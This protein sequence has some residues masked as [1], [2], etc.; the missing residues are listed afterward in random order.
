[1]K[2]NWEGLLHDKKTVLSLFVLGAMGFMALLYFINPW[3]LIVPGLFMGLVLFVWAVVTDTGKTQ[4]TQVKP[5]QYQ[6]QIIQG[7]RVLIPISNENNLVIN[8]VYQDQEEEPVFYQPG[9]KWF[10]D[11]R[12]PESRRRLSI[13]RDT[14]P[15]LVN[16]T[17]DTRR[18]LIN[19]SRDT[20]RDLINIGKQ[21]FMGGNR[22]R[23][24]F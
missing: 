14:R 10:P 3:L 8:G 4:I 24:L 23:R 6:E 1:M 12:E 5:Q 20:R 21:E 19:T 9:P 22:K 7:Q 16:P 13:G 18:E 17:R 15:S 11:R 2:Q